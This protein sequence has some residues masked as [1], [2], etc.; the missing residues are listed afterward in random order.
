MT[1]TTCCPVLRM[2]LSDCG[3]SKHSRVWWDIKDTTIQYGIHS[4]LLTG[5]TLCQGDMTEW[6]GK[7][8]D[9]FST[10]QFCGELTLEEIIG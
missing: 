1:G 8:L 3:A 5:I 4:S 7:K 6:L 2:V 9:E 10:Y